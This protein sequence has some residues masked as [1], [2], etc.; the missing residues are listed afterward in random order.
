MPNGKVMAAGRRRTA[1]GDPLALA[2]G[3]AVVL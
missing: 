2:S 1:D 3:D